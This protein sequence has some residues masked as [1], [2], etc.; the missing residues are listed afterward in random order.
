MS[1]D[2]LLKIEMLAQSVID[3]IRDPLLL[4]DKDF[5][6]IAAS[7]SYYLTYETDRQVAHGQM[8]SALGGGRWDISALQKQLELIS[9]QQSVLEAFEVEVELPRKGQ[10]LVLIHARRLFSELGDSAN[11]LLAIEDI[12]ER[13]A[14]ERERD[15][16]LRQKD[17]QLA[18]IEHRI[19]NSLAIIAGILL[20]K[21][22]TVKSEETRAHLE[23]AHRR[24][25]SVAAVQKHLHA[26]N[27]AGSIEVGPYLTQLCSS[28]S[29]AMINEDQC[30]LKVHAPEGAVPSKAAVSIGLI[31]TELVLNAL[32]HAFPDNK[33]GCAI[34]VNY[35]VNGSDWRL[36][37]S[38]NG[39]GKSDI[40]WPPSKSGL[41]MGII[42]A[43]AAQLDA[44]VDTKSGSGGTS[45]FIAHSTFRPRLTVEN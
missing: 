21:A 41:G 22:R 6:V 27:A 37:V 11:I 14:A 38:D 13:R 16:L 33:A 10:R 36:T 3:T 30:E 20:L 31:V 4:L 23:D 17:I 2:E 40:D 5:R 34:T 24:V 18:E 45:V 29:A 42:Q 35:E 15:D 12:T 7:R 43:L 26:T 19:A 32:K 9:P 1:T 25:I 8:L 39:V 44:H 28:L